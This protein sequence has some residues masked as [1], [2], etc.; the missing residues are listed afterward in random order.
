MDMTE[1]APIVEE[2]FDLA[3]THEKLRVRMYAPVLKERTTWACRIELGSPIGLDKE[4][5]GEGSLQAVA[6][7][8]EQLSAVLYSH[9]LYREGKLGAWGEFGGYLGL[10][11][12]STYQDF[13][14]FPF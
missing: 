11:A 12:P 4:V 5:L 6:L 3:D 14:P 10:P 13:A 7:A 2:Q 1:Q 9:P 8:L